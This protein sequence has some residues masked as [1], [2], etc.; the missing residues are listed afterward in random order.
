MIYSRILWVVLDSVGIGAMPDAADFGDDPRSDTLGNIARVRNLNLPNLRRIGL[1]N[2][3]SF[4][5]L[6]PVPSPQ[7]AFGRCALA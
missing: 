2:I 6:D 1:A 7:G 3:R 4:P 5:A